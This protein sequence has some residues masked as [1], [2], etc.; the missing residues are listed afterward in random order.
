MSFS[1]LDKQKVE[2]VDQYIS[3]LGI[4]K[5][6][7]RSYL[8]QTLHKAQSI[9]GHLPSELQ[10]YIAKKLEI[11][12][13]EVYGVVS[14]YSYFTTVKRGKYVLSVCLGTA[15]YVKGAQKILDDLKAEL[16]VDLD[17]TTKDGLF[18]IT[19]L[20]CIG[21]CGLAPVMLV[22]GKAYGNLTGVKA[23]SILKDYA[24]KKEE[25]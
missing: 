2:E 14:F 22:N 18:T 19:A 24:N 23:L 17:E 5:D 13:S 6:N 3:G 10:R 15:C 21:A 25:L 16:G 20:R 9:F 1:E 7:G 4:S 11:P 12:A 8:I